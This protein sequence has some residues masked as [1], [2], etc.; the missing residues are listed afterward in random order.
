[1]KKF[2]KA[3]V[4]VTV[5]CMALS[6]V[7]FA[8][9]S[10]STTTAPEKIFKV[11]VTDAGS[12]QVALYIVEAG[13]PLTANPLYI[14][15]MGAVDGEAEFT[16]VLTNKTVEAVDVYVGYATYADLKAEPLK[17]DTVKLVQP[18]TEVTI[19]KVDTDFVTANGV[20]QVGAGAALTVNVK[21]PNGISATDMIWAIRYMDGDVERVKYTESFDISGLGLGTVLKGDV[22]LG[23][24]F[25]NG[26]NREGEEIASVEITDV[27]AIF[28]FTGGHGEKYTNA[29]DAANKLQ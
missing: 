22:Q 18:I 24:A 17:V 4:F 28:M 3:I 9:G 26:F 29:D 14:D 15:Q 8:A 10:V 7:A 20:Q 23:L 11:T 27:D 1:M 19:S 16:A 13:D 2:M 5:M 6:T 21:A 12:D 25:L